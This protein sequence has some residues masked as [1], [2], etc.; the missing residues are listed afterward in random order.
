M[1][2]AGLVLTGLV[3]MATA[4]AWYGLR[5]RS[6]VDGDTCVVAQSG[7]DPWSWQDTVLS[8]SGDDP[9]DAVTHVRSVAPTGCGSASG[10]AHPS[11]ARH[12]RL[13]A[14]L[15]DRAAVVAV[16]RSRRARPADAGAYWLY[17]LRGR[18]N[19]EPAVKVRDPT[20]SSGRLTW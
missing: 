10:T 14:R 3:V 5:C 20:A 1:S 19:S 15:R 4:V 6:S 8:R 11:T 17:V 2:V 7:G 12:P 13:K 16:T 9:T 18:C